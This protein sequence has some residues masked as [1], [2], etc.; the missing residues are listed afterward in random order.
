MVRQIAAQFSKSCP[1]LPHGFLG[2]LTGEVISRSFTVCRLRRTTLLRREAQEF[3]N[4]RVRESY[5]GRE[6]CGWA[7]SRHSW[8]K[9]HTPRENYR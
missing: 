6:I 1:N 3:F 4:A 7:G 2:L 8:S 9:K 5:T